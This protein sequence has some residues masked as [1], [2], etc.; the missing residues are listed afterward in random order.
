[1]ANKHVV[2]PRVVVLVLTLGLGLGCGLKRNWSVCTTEVP[3]CRPGFT[4]N[5]EKS[6][7]EKTVDGGTRDG[8]P[9]ASP[10]TRGVIVPDAET[11]G[12]AFVAV[13]VTAMAPDTG[14]PDLVALITPDAAPV[15]PD[16]PAAGTSSDVSGAIRPMDTLPPAPDLLTDTAATIPSPDALSPD[17]ASRDTGPADVPAPTPDVAIGCPGACCADTDCQGTCQVCSAN[18]TC[19]AAINKDDPTGR[20][21]GTCDATGA[22]KS[23][24]GQ[25]CQT[26]ASCLNG[27]TCSP[28]G[29]CCDRECKGACEACDLATSPGICTAITGTPHPG[30]ATC[31]GTS[32]DCAGSCMGAANGQCTWPATACG[33]ASCTTLTNSQAQPIGTSFVAKGT[34]SA[35]TC[36]TPSA[37][38]CAGGVICASGTGCKPSCVVDSDCLTGNTCGSG[39]TC[40]GKKATGGSCFGANECV[41]GTCADGFCCENACAGACL[42]CSSAKTGAS[43]GLCRPVSAGTDPDTECSVDT[44]NEC[45]RDGTCDGLGSCRLQVTGIV[46]GHSSCNNGILTPTGKCNGSGTCIAATTSGPCPGNMLCA[47]TTTCATT[48]TDRST[49]GCPVGYKCVGG[50]SCVVDMIRCG[51]SGSCQVGNGG[52]CCVTTAPG[53]AN[54]PWIYTCLSSLDSCKEWDGSSGHSI[55]CNSQT[56]CPAGQLCC[57]TGISC[58]GSSTPSP[59]SFCTADSTQCQD[60]PYS[61]G[62]QVCDPNLLPSECPSG[63]CKSSSCVHGMSVCQP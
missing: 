55:I 19:I 16:A 62:G 45:G 50:N 17:T 26:T 32:L 12:D 41:S 56:D 36:A 18:H 24:Q 42:A 58:D 1:M 14:Q 39:G 48:C 29:R 27:M 11:H 61:W 5:F 53:P 60:G 46:C 9:L 38:S 15:V 21:A 52:N 49:T 40:V 44:S 28:D 22:C 43:N 4:C 25:A 10:D 54:T 35:G 3:N 8:A 47:S 63:I 59:Y 37:T 57:M 34:C 30:H 2:I 6:A 23:K 20:C 31:E 51:S 13:D 7:C 33:Q